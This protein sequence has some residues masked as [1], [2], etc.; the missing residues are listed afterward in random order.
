MVINNRDIKRKEVL[1]IALKH[2]ST[3]GYEKT[4]LLDIAN[5][6]SVST[7]TIYSFFN[8]KYDLYE[9][10]I[11]YSLGVINDELQKIVDNSS[12]LEE[13]IK[14][15][16]EKAYANAECE[17]QLLNF[18]ML[19]TTNTIKIQKTEIIEEFEKQKFSYYLKFIKFPKVK[20]RYILLFIDNVI[21]I[22]IYS[23][24]NTF[25]RK[26]LLLYLSLYKEHEI[27]SDFKKTLLKYLQEWIRKLDN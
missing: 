11:E 16:A 12:T 1:T 13:Y 21:N 20:D 10:V 7:T 3:F 17:Q 15:V 22:Y 23:F 18:Y 27:K 2:F 19:V 5:E 26:K 8:T 4:K 9:S 14:H 24:F 6:A 25:Y